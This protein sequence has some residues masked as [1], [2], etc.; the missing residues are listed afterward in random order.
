MDKRSTLKDLSAAELKQELINRLRE[1]IQKNETENEALREQIRQL[2]PEGKAIS[3][4]AGRSRTLA[5]NDMSLREVVAQVLREAGEPLRVK[6]IIERVRSAG[7]VSKATNFAGIVNISL[8]NNE[9][10]FEKVGRG[11]YKLRENALVAA[12]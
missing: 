5:K 8:S 2:M 1:Q 7:Y 10:L 9:E 12:E 11:V 3:G 4:R 6:E